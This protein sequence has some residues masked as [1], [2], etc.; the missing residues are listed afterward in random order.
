[1]IKDE[2]DLEF[3][4]QKCKELG[5]KY[6]IYPEHITINSTYD[7]WFFKYNS[8]YKKK[9]SLYHMNRIKY[10][11][12]AYHF[13]RGFYDICYMLNNIKNH[14]QYRVSKY[15][16]NASRIGQLFAKVEAQG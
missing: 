16:F 14:D 2:I 8:T 13:Q 3:L 12:G 7:E 4:E 5:L 9:F 6:K 1:M 15:D 10:S 11:Q